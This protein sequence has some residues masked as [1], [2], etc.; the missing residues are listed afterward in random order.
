MTDY[1]VLNLGAGV[2]STFLYLQFAFGLMTPRIDAAVFADTQEEPGDVY[3]HLRWLRSVGGPPILT[4]TAGK[5]GEDLMH[6]RRF[7]SIPAYTTADAGET[8]GITRRQCSKEYKI[9]VIGQVIRRELL[10]LKPGGRV[11]RGVTIHQYFGISLNESGRAV[12]ILR[13][14]RPKYVVCHFPLLERFIVRSQCEAWLKDRVPHTVPRS[15]CVFCPYH[16]DAEWLRLKRADPDAWRRAVE[17]DEALRGEG[18][19]ARRGHNGTMYLH[20][21]CKPLALVELKPNPDPRLTQSNLNF[22]PECLG[23]CGV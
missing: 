14:R 6:R 4:G 8:V 22:A 15:A 9:E 3:E 21:S 18:T 17:I 2:Q 5:L 1:H 12:R 20:R 13:A 7:A 16:S 23:V 10:G 11:P 19:T